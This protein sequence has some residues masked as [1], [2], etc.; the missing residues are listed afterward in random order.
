V[1]RTEVQRAFKN[2][3]GGNRGEAS[4]GAAVITLSRWKIDDKKQASRPLRGGLRQFDA[5]YDS[6]RFSRVKLTGFPFV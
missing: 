1:R 5:L 2:H 3:C 4:G 6:K